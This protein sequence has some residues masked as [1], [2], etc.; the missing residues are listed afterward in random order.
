MRG[1]PS[2]ISRSVVL[3]PTP[4]PMLKP[5]KKYSTQIHDLGVKTYYRANI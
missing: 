1:P 2:A 3:P 4:N 5:E